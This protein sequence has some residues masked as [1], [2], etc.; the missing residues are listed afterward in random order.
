M[1]T[2]GTTPPP[3]EALKGL[4]KWFNKQFGQKLMNMGNILKRP[5]QTDTHS[6]A[7]C[8]MSTIAHGVLGDPLW[9][10]CDASAHRIHWFLKLDEY[11][12]PGEAVSNSVHADHTQYT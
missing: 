2:S 7:I 4:R 6:C 11:Y 8:A 12:F 5:H 9:I 1:V 3:G 10:Q